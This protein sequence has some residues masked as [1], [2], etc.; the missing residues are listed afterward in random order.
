MERDEKNFTFLMNN[1]HK[2]FDSIFIKNLLK[3]CLLFTR[4]T[5]TDFMMKFT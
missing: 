4:E 1:H 2:T 3:S 5:T